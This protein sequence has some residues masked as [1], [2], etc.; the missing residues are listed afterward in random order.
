[1]LFVKFISTCGLTLFISGL[2]KYLSTRKNWLSGA[3]VPILTVGI[4]AIL[5]SFTKVPFSFETLAPCAVLIALELFIWVDGRFQYK[6][7]EIRK[8]KAKDIA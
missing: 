3:I 4:L 6:R 5:F 1:M 2:Q 7:M 8:M